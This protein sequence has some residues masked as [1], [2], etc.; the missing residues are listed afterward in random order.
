MIGH[1]LMGQSFLITG[2]IAQGRAISIR[3]LRFTIPP[4]IVHWLRDLAK[5]LGWLPCAI[6]R[7]VCGCL[8][9]Q[10]PRLRISSVLLK[11]AR[12]I[13]QAATLMFALSHA[14]L[15]YIFCGNYATAS[16]LATNLSLW[17]TRKAHRSGKRSEP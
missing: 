11:D 8:V 17:R 13:G 10:R 7:C 5:T 6:V 3:R 16:A 2:D 9:I 14:Q 1:R 4:S 12:D 15:P